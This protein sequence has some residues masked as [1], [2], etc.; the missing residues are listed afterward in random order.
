MKTIGA[1]RAFDLDVNNDALFIHL[2]GRVLTLRGV[3]S[4]F[5]ASLPATYN[6]SDPTGIYRTL[7]IIP[8]EGEETIVVLSPL[9]RSGSLIDRF[10]LTEGTSALPLDR[11]VVER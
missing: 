10:D 8:V 3:E 4:P 6:V 5:D 9:R 7:Q 1:N 11:N 2:N